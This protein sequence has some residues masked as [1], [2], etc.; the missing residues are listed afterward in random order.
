MKTM[1]NMDIVDQL[2]STSLSAPNKLISNR[3]PDIDKEPPIDHWTHFD[4][5]QFC[6][7]QEEEM[8][9]WNALP[10]EVKQKGE[11]FLAEM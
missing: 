8:E 2:G 11:A 9:L 4:W 10:D 6:M 1:S 5:E 3:D 7:I